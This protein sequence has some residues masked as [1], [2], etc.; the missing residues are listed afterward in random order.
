M[1]GEILEIKNSFVT[2]KKNADVSSDIINLYVKVI[3]K[4]KKY[5]GEIVSFTKDIIEIKLFGEIVNNTFIHGLNTKPSFNSQV[6]LLEDS[7]IKILFGLNNYQ[8]ETKLY[9]GKSTIY[10]NYPIYININNLFANHLVVLGNTGSGKSCGMARIMQNLFYKKDCNPINSTFFIIDAY[11]EY[12]NA[13]S[14]I[15]YTNHNLRLKSYKTKNENNSHLLQIPLWLLSLDDICLLLEIK[16]KNQIP[17][18]EKALKIVN[19]FKR[20]DEEVV[21]Y[22]NSIIS[23]ALLD[24]FINGKTPAQIRDQVFSVL[25]RYNT[26]NL[27]LES[28]IYMPG[29]TRPL[30]QCLKIDET[31]K[32]R[33]MELVINFLQQFLLEEMH[34][35]LPDGTFV[36][37]LKDLLYAFDFALIDEGILNSDHIYTIA[38]ELRV[39]LASLV[40]SESAQYFEFDRYFSKQAFFKNLIYENGERCQVI[41]LN[42]SELDDRFAKI[43]AKIYSKFLFDYVKNETKRATVPIH[44]VLEEAHRYVQMDKDI[45][46]LGYNI[47]E[48]IAKEGRKY[49]I[50]LNLISQRPS[51]LSQT[52]LS[53]CNN[54]LVFKITHPADIEYIKAMIPYVDDEMVEKIKNLQVGNCLTFGTAFLIPTITK[55]DMATPAPSSSSCDI[56]KIWFKEENSENVN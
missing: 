55:I 33:D 18:V 56:S 17:I 34:L 3:D 41:N 51:E 15:N 21:K 4:K 27:N 2:L 42:L 19:V 13:F 45:E 20:E 8:P 6:S 11:G 26:K 46:I 10:E 40:D 39:R 9:L 28:P 37:T 43:V 48:R 12:Q 24:I 23:K 30:K 36:Y 44:I 49:G 53:Q 54:F 50:L 38:N 7:E 35:N 14:S 16:N 52:V 5:V 25:T 32:I 1:L 31:G 22:K 29:Y 47:F